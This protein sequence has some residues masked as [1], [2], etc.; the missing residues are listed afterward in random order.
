MQRVSSYLL[1]TIDE[2]IL[3]EYGPKGRSVLNVK[4]IY[5]TYG[6]MNPRPTCICDADY[7]QA[8]N[9]KEI[10]EFSSTVLEWRAD[11]VLCS[12]PEMHS[13]A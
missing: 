10:S 2:C 4:R 9:D 5:Y 13:M 1:G 6:K 11:G 7:M 8:S 12:M 3:L